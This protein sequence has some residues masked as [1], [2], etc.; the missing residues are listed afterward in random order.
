MRNFFLTRRTT[1]VGVVRIIRRERVHLKKLA[2]VNTNRKYN[3]EVKRIEV[4]RDEDS[5][6]PFLFLWEQV[7]RKQITPATSP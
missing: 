4:I 6:A 7:D 3:C 1:A 5:S 2:T